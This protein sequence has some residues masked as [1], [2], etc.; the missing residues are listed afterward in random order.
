MTEHKRNARNKYKTD[1]P[2]ILSQ[3]DASE[4]AET[5]FSFGM[6]AP[7]QATTMTRTVD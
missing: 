5:V 4:N 2:V 3:R 1:I 7:F 6:T